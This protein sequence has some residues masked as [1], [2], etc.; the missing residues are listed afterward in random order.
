ML[1]FQ[2]LQ[3]LVPCHPQGGVQAPGVAQGPLP[4]LVSAFLLYCNS[5]LFPKFP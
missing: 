5:M 4:G 3:W 1:W 2:L